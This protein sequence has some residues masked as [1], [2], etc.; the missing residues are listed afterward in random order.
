MHKEC[1][2]VKNFAIEAENLKWN[3]RNSKWMRGFLNT[4]SAK[5]GLKP[6]KKNFLSL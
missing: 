6:S 5:Q 3:C 4:T 2:K 1:N